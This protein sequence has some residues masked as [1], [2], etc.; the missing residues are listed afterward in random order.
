MKKIFY[1]VLCLKKGMNIKMKKQHNRSLYRCGT[2][3]LIL[4]MALCL[5]TFNGYFTTNAYAAGAN[6]LELPPT[7]VLDFTNKS[8]ER[9]Y[10]SASVKSF[11]NPVSFSCSVHI[12]SSDRGNVLID[13]GYY[14]DEVKAYIK[15][16][17]GLDAIIITHAH[18][19]H[20]IGLNALSKDYSDAKVYINKLD[21]AALYDPVLN[22]SLNNPISKPIIYEGQAI[23]LSE[24][25]YTIA[26]YKVSFIHT[27]GHSP[28]CSIFYF[29][30]DDFLFTGDAIASI[31]FGGTT[32]YNWPTS[33]AP[34][35]FRSFE[36][37]K[38]LNIPG[39]T[40]VFFGHGEYT[41]FKKMISTYPIFKNKFLG[42]KTDQGTILIPDV[43]IVGDE[44]L[45]PIRQVGET[46]GGTISWDNVTK[47]ASLSLPDQTLL[48]TQ[49]GNDDIIV[50]GQT[51]EADI[52]TQLHDG[53]TYISGE[54]LAVE[55]RA[56]IQWIIEPSPT[57]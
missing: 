13:P 51:V 29:E 6:E 54:V 19:D 43:Y 44:I 30:D 32:L 24:G 2:L 16:I 27:P 10:Q 41:T 14:D 53:K 40:K 8:P 1:N 56:Y 36:K 23:G 9:F 38:N 42:I 4:L 33:N 7:P 45:L 12:I 18:V 5:N 26:D 52:S 31:D 34:E 46:I 28:G 37:I 22:M 3:V 50:D 11:V 47:T 39:N 21:Q 15:S 20:I 17:G 25:T 48:K 55:L 35:T 57:R 49:I